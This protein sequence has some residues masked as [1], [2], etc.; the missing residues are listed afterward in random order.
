MFDPAASSISA[1]GPKKGR[2]SRLASRRPTA[3]LPAP[4]SPI[5]TMLREPSASRI[6]ANRC[7]RSSFL[8]SVSPKL[9]V[10]KV[11]NCRPLRARG[12]RDS[13]AG[14]FPMLAAPC[15]I[16][17]DANEVKGLVW[18]LGRNKGPVRDYKT[19]R[20]SS[21]AM[22]TLFRF[23]MILGL[24]ASVVTGSLYVLA[25]YFQPEP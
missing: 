14:Q 18:F 23:L 13:L 17:H 7:S 1:S 2:S 15:R 5:S 21:A 4:M 20:K 12:P 8:C 10:A 3:V 9:I 16:V 25:E 22:P 24:I 11:E 19:A 6:S